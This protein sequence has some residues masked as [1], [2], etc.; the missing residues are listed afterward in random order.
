MNTN[1]FSI[2]NVQRHLMPNIDTVLVVI[3]LLFVNNVYALNLNTSA[4]PSTISYQGV[5][6][7]AGGTPVNTNVGLTFRLYNVQSGGTALWTET[8]SSVLINNGLFHVQLGSITSIPSSVWDNSAVYLGVQVTGDSAELS[9]REVVSAVPYAMNF[10]IPDG[11]VTNAKIASG[12]V[13]SDKLAMTY[14]NINIPS[15]TDNNFWTTT[16]SGQLVTVPSLQFSYTP[17]KMGLCF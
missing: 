17:P 3:A 1:A 10:Q 9:P 4:T 15:A 2:K 12:A 14:W 11:S 16:L 7:N 13:T 6:S 5:L 8:H